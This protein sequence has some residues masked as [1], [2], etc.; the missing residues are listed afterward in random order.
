MRPVGLDKGVSEAS[1]GAWSLVMI[2][3]HRTEKL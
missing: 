3:Y 2:S 1:S